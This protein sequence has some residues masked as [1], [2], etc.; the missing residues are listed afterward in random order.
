M[1]ILSII[2]AT[3][4]GMFLGAL[5]YS[6]ILFGKQ[7]MHCIGKT[8]ETLGSA[9]VPMI[10]SIFASVLSAVGVGL[11]H[12]MMGVD[13]LAISIYVGLILGLLIVFPALLSDNLFCGWGIPLLLIQAGYR[14]FSI[15]LMSLAIFL[16]G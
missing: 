7:W 11:I 16:V 8:Q 3:L 2:V 6:P 5:W 13:T 1:S 14:V 9:T 4:V 10:G 15:V 12:F